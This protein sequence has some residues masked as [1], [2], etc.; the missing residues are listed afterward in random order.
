MSHHALILLLLAGPLQARQDLVCEPTLRTPAANVDS[1]VRVLF[2]GNSHTYVNQLPCLVQRLASSLQ[3][4]IDL[5]VVAV[6]RDGA[7][8]EQHWAD[9]STRALSQAREWDFVVLQEQGRRPVQHPEL[10]S[11]AV[12][13]FADAVRRVGA[14]LVL[15]IPP[16]A[17]GR[18]SELP[19]TAAVYQE[20]AA[21]TRSTIA[22]VA[23][24]W[25]DAGRADSTLRLHGADGVH[26]SAMGSYLSAC[27]L[28]AAITARSP[29][30][31]APLLL[32]RP[33]G[34]APATLVIP[35]TL[36]RSR[37]TALQAA[38]WRAVR[39]SS[40]VLHQS[41]PLRPAES[42]RNARREPSSE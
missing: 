33:Y 22:P 34:S 6:A 8:L 11:A 28:L 27:V 18:S 40:A 5:E 24:A 15:Y 14:R 4:R 9:S 10:T 3:P 1:P 29:E 12:R 23:Q 2:L 41:S 26:A 38:A 17:S 32:R 36:E 25:E 30:G 7:T 21:A 31:V 20:I 16:L 37:A 19:G 39:E 35:D 13:R 42:T